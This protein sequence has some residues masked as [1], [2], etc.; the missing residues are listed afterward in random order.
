MKRLKLTK[1]IA[2]TL[3]AASVLALN[4]IGASAE[5]ESNSTGWWYTEGNSYTTE[6]KN[7]DGNWYYFYSDGYMATNN[8]I[9]GYFVNSTGAWTN[10]ITADETRQLIINED[11]NYIS[12]VS[13]KDK[14]NQ[15]SKLETDYK[16]YNAENMPTRNGWDIP[17]E[18]CYE[19][20]VNYYNSKDKVLNGT[21]VYLVGEQSKNVYCIPNQGGMLAYQIENN[22]KVKAFKC[23]NTGNSYEWHQ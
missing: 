18:P 23:M 14:Y 11:G 21:C 7:I 16:E 1:T 22:Q 2:A 5:W 19:F 15:Y 12:K 13:K 10:S 6:W 20:C 8:K 3:I 17:K 9:D 4:P